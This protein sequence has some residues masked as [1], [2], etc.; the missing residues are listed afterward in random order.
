[1]LAAT[2]LTR[3]RTLAISTQDGSKCPDR[4]LFQFAVSKPG[5]QEGCLL[6]P[7]A[8]SPV[9]FFEASLTEQQL[10]ASLMCINTMKLLRYTSHR[11]ACCS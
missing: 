3:V 10:L 4:L 7:S 8:L 2:G 11:A 9:L 5:L 6:K 1:M